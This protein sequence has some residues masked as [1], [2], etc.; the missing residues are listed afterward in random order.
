MA[1]CSPI[2]AIFAFVGSAVGLAVGLFL[3]KILFLKF[4]WIMENEINF[5][6]FLGVNVSDAMNGLWGYNAVLSC[7]ALGGVFYIL[8]IKQVILCVMG[9]VSSLLHSF[10]HSFYDIILWKIIYFDKVKDF[11]YYIVGNI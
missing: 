11:M 2:S 6:L 4:T 5:K 3:G 9:G 7:V 10:I 8:C 1:F